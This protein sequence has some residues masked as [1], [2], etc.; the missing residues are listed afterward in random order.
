MLERL[1]R[2]LAHQTYEQIDQALQSIPDDELFQLIDGRSIKVGESACGVLGARMRP[3]LADLLVDALLQGRFRTKLGRVRASSMLNGFG[4][5]APRA[6]EAY[7]HLL[8]DRSAGVRDNALFGLVFLQDKAHLP[9]IEAARD[10]LPPGS[11][12]R[13]EFDCGIKALREGNLFI[14]S[15]HFADSQ[16]A[17]GLK[18]FTEK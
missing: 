13:P 16:N 15:P 7:L 11:E 17:W 10:A 9:A 6:H 2:E 12:Q 8:H 4:K 14:L 5:G 18:G 3:G 1:E